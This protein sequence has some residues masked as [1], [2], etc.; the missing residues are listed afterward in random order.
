MLRISYYE[1]ESTCDDSLVVMGF[2][3][4]FATFSKSTDDMQPA[5]ARPS[6]VCASLWILHS[7]R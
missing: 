5:F 3:D 1:V 6:Y 2:R 4:V 7:A